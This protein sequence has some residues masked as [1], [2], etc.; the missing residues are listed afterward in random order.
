MLPSSGGG[1]AAALPGKGR[2]TDR[3]ICGEN[4][5]VFLSFLFLNTKGRCRTRYGFSPDYP[6]HNVGDQSQV[7]DSSARAADFAPGQ[8]HTVWPTVQQFKLVWA[9]V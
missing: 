8:S 6:V 2:Q 4:L 1:A 7:C 3:Q 5:S 9:S